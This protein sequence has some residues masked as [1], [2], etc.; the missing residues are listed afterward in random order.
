MSAVV[1]SGLGLVT[2]LGS[3]VDATFD[4]ILAG[5]HGVS[6][7][8]AWDT[9]LYATHLAAEIKFPLAYSDSRFVKTL[10]RGHSLLL[11]AVKEALVEAGLYGKTQGLKVGVIVGTSLAG[12]KSMQLYDAQLYNENSVLTEHLVN[13]PLHLC[14]DLV[15][16]EFDFIGPRQVISTACTA[17]T[18][19]VGCAVAML[20]NGKADVVIAAG[21]DPLSTISYTGFSCM[22][23]MS[24]EP[25]AP[26]SEPIGLTLGE[27]AGAIVLEKE[28]MA[29]TRKK[30]FYVYVRDYMFTADA[31][32]VTNPEPRGTATQHL[33][34]SLLKKSDITIKDIDY[35]NLHGTGTSGNDLTETKIID[36]LFYQHGN[37]VACSSTK[38]AT[39]HTL[40]AAG[41]IES[42]LTVKAM[43]ANKLL[44]TANY[45]EPRKGC[46]LNCVPNSSQSATIN[47]AFV[48]NFAFGGN[49]AAILM[50][51]Q[52]PAVSSKVKPRVVVTGMSAV[53][54]LG[55]DFA[56]VCKNIAAGV[57]A[58]KD[59]YSDSYKRYFKAAKL[60]DFNL[61]NFV[62]ADARRM[63]RLTQITVAATYLALA[64]SGLGRKAFA[65]S[66]IGL[67][68]GTMFGHGESNLNFHRDILTKSPDKIDPYGFPNTVTNAGT[69]QAA[70]VNRLKGCN[71]ALSMGQA[72]GLA[73]IQLA[74]ELIQDG[75][76]PII[77]AG[78]ADELID[79]ML[80]GYYR[81]GL[82]RG[83]SKQPVQLLDR[84]SL[85]EGA[86]YFVLEE[87]QHAIDRGAHIYAEI[88]DCDSF[89]TNT[90]NNS[91][92]FDALSQ[93][94][95]RFLAKN[96]AIT[97]LENVYGSSLNYK[98][99]SENEMVILSKLIGEHIGVTNLHHQMG[100]S[101]MTSA[102]S[103]GLACAAQNQYSLVNAA[104]LGGSYYSTLVKK[105]R[106]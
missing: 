93:Q 29:Q 50:S 32:H 37:S 88:I 73:A 20:R 8:E 41:I 22:R 48:Q 91:V 96:T 43:H 89:A 51:K 13:Q 66:Y 26:F 77:V 45:K 104:S 33:I 94:L 87:Y 68:S 56:E 90:P 61:R 58:L 25:S 49:N 39:G 97:S 76:H 92:S 74:Y 67:V 19:A 4:N 84:L 10:D 34:N 81:S 36:Q 7:V 54:P 44:P 64:D 65:E 60:D 98:K 24:H 31:Y 2:A 80:Y 27:G 100:M 106:N 11:A 101:A 99:F 83:N 14:A 1:A 71:I 102:I 75:L 46:S 69:G 30:S 70:I 5:K 35:I 23:N 3:N 21:C 15:A 95:E 12:M 6:E 9:S 63:D 17:S 55:Y 85:N 42:V 86:S 53:T 57:S 18:I 82:S 78:G 40:G 28:E 103:F 72:S 59:I 52:K 105:W 38:G 16:K 79:Y 62:K 47:T